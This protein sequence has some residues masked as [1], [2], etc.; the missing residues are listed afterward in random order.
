MVIWINIEGS[1]ILFNE[2]NKYYLPNVP[3]G[4]KNDPT[5][6]PMMMINFIAQN[7]FCIPALGSLDFLTPIMMREKSRKNRVT[8]KQSLKI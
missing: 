3:T 7:P 8:M 1:P 2:I 5:I 6:P 4:M